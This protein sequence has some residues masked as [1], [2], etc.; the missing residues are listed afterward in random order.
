MGDI[1]LSPTTRTRRIN[2]ILDYLESTSQPCI[3]KLYQGVIPASTITAN[4]ANLLCELTLNKPFGSV[5]GTNL[6]LN[7]SGVT[8][9]ATAAGT[10]T[11]AR[12]YLSAGACVLDSAVGAG[13]P[14]TMPNYDLLVGTAVTI[15]SFV[16][17]EG[18]A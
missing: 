8:G 11:Y 5:S 13:K 4:E 7:V 2:A 6:T 18:N 17:S 12:V 16:I 10:V 9:F 15:S 14:I 1:R 3:L